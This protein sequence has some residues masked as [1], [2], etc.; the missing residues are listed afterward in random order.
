MNNQNPHLET[1][2]ALTLVFNTKV[3]QKAG[4]SIAI[5]VEKDTL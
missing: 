1:V 3:P 4:K 5:E 2:R